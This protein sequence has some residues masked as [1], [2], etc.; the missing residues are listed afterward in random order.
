MNYAV[1]ILMVFSLSLL[2]CVITLL[3]DRRHERERFETQLTYYREELAGRDKQLAMMTETQAAYYAMKDDY[4]KI[5]IRLRED[6]KQEIAEGNHAG[7]SLSAIVN[8]YL[9]RERIFTARE[10]K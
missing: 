5:A 2:V 10:R 6:Y 9:T 4:D 1:L 7:R 8:G 3:R